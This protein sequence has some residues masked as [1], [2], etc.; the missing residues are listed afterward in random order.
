MQIKSQ[1]FNQQYEK[2]DLYASTPTTNNCPFLTFTHTLERKPKPEARQRNAQEKRR[3]S[4][5]LSRRQDCIRYDPM[6]HFLWHFITTKLE[7]KGWLLGE[8]TE[9]PS[10]GLQ[11]LKISQYPTQSSLQK[12]QPPLKLA[13]WSLHQTVNRHVRLNPS[14]S[15]NGNARHLSSMVIDGRVCCTHL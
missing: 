14:H 7:I 4:A 11:H 13:A 10:P 8:V 9:V 5:D 3:K 12:P 1:I 2:W 6:L 15:G